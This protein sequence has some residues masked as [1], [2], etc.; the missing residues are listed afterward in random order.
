MMELLIDLAL[1]GIFYHVVPVA[2]ALAVV[3]W[4]FGD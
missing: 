2:M 4:V 1:M 3:V